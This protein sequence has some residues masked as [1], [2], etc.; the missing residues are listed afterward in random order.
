MEKTESVKIEEIVANLE[1]IKKENM[2]IYDIAAI[3]IMDI[4]DMMTAPTKESFRKEK[5]DLRTQLKVLKR[6]I[7]NKIFDG[8][9]HFK[10]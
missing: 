8:V 10:K 7:D 6:I 4:H 5:S 1:T 3:V 9:K 2:D